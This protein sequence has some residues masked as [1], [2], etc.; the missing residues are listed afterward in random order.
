MTSWLV[1]VSSAPVGSS[2]RMIA[3]FV[4]ERARDG[5]AL[6]LAAGELRRLVVHAVGEP[7]RRER[8]ARASRL[9]SLSAAIDERQLDL[10]RAPSGAAAG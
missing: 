4:D 9:R 8:A 5:D 6:L 2:A 7:D 1:F 10:R 3:G